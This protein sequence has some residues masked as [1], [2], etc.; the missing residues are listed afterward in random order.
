MLNWTMDYK[1][2]AL[3]TE[4]TFSHTFQCK[5]YFFLLVLESIIRVILLGTVSIVADQLSC[6]RSMQCKD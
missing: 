5:R 2:I 4:F 3:G 6:V 1:V